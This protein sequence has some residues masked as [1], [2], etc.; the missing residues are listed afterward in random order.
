MFKPQEEGTSPSKTLA[1]NVPIGECGITTSEVAASGTQGQAGYTPA[2]IHHVLYLNP[3]ATCVPVMHQLK[4]T[5]KH[6]VDHDERMVLKIDSK[7]FV[8]IFL[9]TVKVPQMSK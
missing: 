1:W 6:D 2:Q 5:C 9:K 7:A 4:L 8:N 3:S